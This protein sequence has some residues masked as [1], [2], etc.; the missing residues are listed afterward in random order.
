M[1]FLLEVWGEVVLCASVH[2]HRKQWNHQLEGKQGS[3]HMQQFAHHCLVIVLEAT[4]AH[5]SDTPT[6]CGHTTK[7]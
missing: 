6:A 2:Y 3:V 1:L 7:T 4:A 5:V